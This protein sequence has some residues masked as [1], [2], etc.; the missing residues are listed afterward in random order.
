M[1]QIV[2]VSFKTR[3][4]A[5]S[6]AR[7]KVSYSSKLSNLSQP[8]S[9]ASTLDRLGRYRS[10]CSCRLYGG[11]AKIKSTEF[12]GS[13]ERTSMQLPCRMALMGQLVTWKDFQWHFLS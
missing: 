4:Q 12:S 13:V 1:T 5:E 3:R 9:T 11:S 7:V 10:F 8:S 6:Q 2:P